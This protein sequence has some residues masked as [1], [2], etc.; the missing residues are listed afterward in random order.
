VFRLDPTAHDQQ[1]VDALTSLFDARV[2]LQEADAATIRT[3]YADSN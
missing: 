3:R 2:T 1:T